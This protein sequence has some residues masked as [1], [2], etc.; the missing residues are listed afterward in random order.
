MVRNEG[1]ADRIVRV[2]LGVV[3]V[4][5]WAPV[6]SLASHAPDISAPWIATIW[7]G[8]CAIVYSSNHRMPA[9]ETH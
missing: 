7:A 1:T 5:A 3:L 8:V 6:L 9:D 2:V 4:A